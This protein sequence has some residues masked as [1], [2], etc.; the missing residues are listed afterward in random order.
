M[1]SGSV[2]QF[3]EEVVFTSQMGGRRR[4]AAGEGGSP[5]TD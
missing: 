4:E 3:T 2:I 5:S 1:P